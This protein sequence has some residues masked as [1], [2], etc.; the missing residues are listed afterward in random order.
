MKKQKILLLLLALVPLT[1]FAFAGCG[2]EAGGNGTGDETQETYNL[3][4]DQ[5]WKHAANQTYH[6]PNPPA[7]LT[8][9]I[10][11]LN[12]GRMAQ[13]NAKKHRCTHN[14]STPIHGREGTTL[15]PFGRVTTPSYNT[16]YAFVRCTTLYWCYAR[17]K[18]NSYISHTFNALYC[19][20]YVCAAVVAHHAVHFEFSLIHSCFFIYGKALDER[21][22][23]QQSQ[24]NAADNLEYCRLF[25]TAGM[26]LHNTLSEPF[27][28]QQIV[29][30]QAESQQQ[31]R[32]H[33][34]Y[35]IPNLIHNAQ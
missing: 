2:G 27:H 20:L 21:V 29:N 10:L 19:V 33:L 6:K 15:F 17:C 14:N 16:Y 5:K 18:I 35:Q 9:I 26:T 8:P 1:A 23:E 12:D 34:I 28:Q 32:W 7:F 30:N 3:V 24:Y 13:T 4:L 25:M 31:V 11:H 22:Y